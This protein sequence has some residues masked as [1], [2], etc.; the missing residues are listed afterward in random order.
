MILRGAG[1][2]AAPW[3]EH[4]SCPHPRAAAAAA[5]PADLLP[6]RAGALRPCALAPALYTRQKTD[7]VQS[8]VRCAFAAAQPAAAADESF[9]TASGC[10]QTAG[11]PAG[12]GRWSEQRRR[13]PAPA[14]AGAAAVEATAPS[15]ES[16]RR[17]PPAARRHLSIGRATGRPAPAVGCG[18]RERFSPRAGSTIP[19][20]GATKWAEQ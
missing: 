17:R 5:A 19:A 14:V 1:R 6:M 11:W 9:R 15:E 12:E 2:A 10:P 4:R 13:H 20:G 8:G 18:E 7:A 16:Q 3:R